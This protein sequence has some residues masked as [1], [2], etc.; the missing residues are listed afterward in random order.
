MLF[1]LFCLL[2]LLALTRRLVRCRLLVLH[3]LVL[4]VHN[5]QLLFGDLLI[6]R[7]KRV[8]PEDEVV[9]ATEQL[10]DLRDNPWR[11]NLLRLEV[12]HDVQ[13]QVVNM[14][15]IRVVLELALDLG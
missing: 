11:V 8:E 2:G 9:M 7:Q 6:W 12:F 5:T 4:L 15:V 1:R 3:R 10:G 13:E 14:R